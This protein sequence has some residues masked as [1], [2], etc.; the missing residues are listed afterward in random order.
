MS[1]PSPQGL[2]AGRWCSSRVV[3]TWALLVLGGCA[4]GAPLAGLLPGHG[5]RRLTPAFS[6]HAR[7]YGPVVDAVRTAVPPGDSPPPDEEDDPEDDVDEGLGAPAMRADAPGDESGSRRRRPVR[8]EDAPLEDEGLVGWRDGVGDGRPWAVPF[9]VDHFQ[10]LLVQ[11]GVSPEVLPEDGSTLSPQ[12]AMRLLGHLLEAEAGLGEFPRQRM[13]AHLL[14]EVATGERPVTREELHARMDRFHRLRVVRPDGYLVR[15]VTGEAVQRAGEVRLAE[16][17][18]LRAG[19]YEVGPF[20]A[21]EDGQLWPVDTGL[22][23]PRG[24]KPLGPYVPDDGVVLPALEGAGLALVDTL[25]SLGQLVFHPGESLEGLARLPEAVRVLFQNAPEYREAFRQ[26]PRGEQVREV[27]RLLANVLLA[28]GTSGAGAVKAVG[29]GEKLGRLSV[30]LLTLTKRGEL[31]LR[32]VAVP[33]RA[34][35]MAG[36]GLG[37]TWGLHLAKVGSGGGGGWVPPVGGPGQ[38]V[39]KNERMS[40]RSRA[41][42][43]KVT[44]AP[45]GW[46][47]RV[48]RNGEKA[49]FDGFDLNQRVLKE[50]KGLGYD[51]HFDADLKARKYFKGAERLIRQARRQSRVANGTPIRWHVA[52]PRMVDILK[53]LFQKESIRGI[54]VVYTPP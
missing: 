29:W 3:L 43:H 15:A 36:Q 22:E 52:E 39:P 4:T 35:T 53:G 21:V 34:V 31:V 12:Q 7:P 8:G 46:V 27:S 42:Q 30:P 1:L 50:T 23:V 26:R 18:T 28:V 45:A 2:P 41:F 32:L 37:V 44:K 13:A 16:D 49:D 38:W 19:R 25:E 33:G 20:Y 40:P 17:G 14:L 9:S 11:V 54:D 6:T 5:S 47:Y 51:K 48:W 24:V 10:G